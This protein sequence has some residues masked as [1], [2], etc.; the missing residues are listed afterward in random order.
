MAERAARSP[1]KLKLCL[2]QQFLNRPYCTTILLSSSL[3]LPLFR[4]HAILNQFLLDFFSVRTIRNILCNESCRV[5]LTMHPFKIAT[6]IIFFFFFPHA[7]SFLPL[8]SE[9]FLSHS[10]SLDLIKHSKE[11]I[12][13]YST[14]G[15]LAFAGILSVAFAQ[16]ST[17]VS[18]LANRLQLEALAAC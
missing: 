11:R 2:R 18:P 7:K 17:M 8:T 15:R 1:S 9:E 14:L 4:L 10:P 5:Y 13:L 16:Q 12:M 6:M 3:L